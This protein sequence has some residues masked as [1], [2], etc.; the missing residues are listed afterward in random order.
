MNSV[1]KL[2]NSAEFKIFQFFRYKLIFK[3]K[4]KKKLKEFIRYY[5]YYQLNMAK[6]YDLDLN[7]IITQSLCNIKKDENI[8][9][10]SFFGNIKK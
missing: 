9:F 7:F 1:S 3:I 6:I 2:K 10:S 4:R 5:N 8:L